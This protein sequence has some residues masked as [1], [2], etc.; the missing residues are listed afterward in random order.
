MNGPI[1]G[2]DSNCS[3]PTDLSCDY[4][5]N[6][7]ENYLSCGPKGY[8]L[9]YGKVYCQRFLDTN[10]TTYQ[11]ELWRDATLLCLQRELSLFVFFSPYEMKTC[12]SIM[13]YAYG[14]HAN[15][16]VSPNRSRSELSIC[17]LSPVD[18]KITTHNLKLV[19]VFRWYGLRQMA[20]VAKLCL[21][22]FNKNKTN[23]YLPG[24]SLE[25]QKIFWESMLI[26]E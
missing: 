5:N 3:R 24:N 19:D 15:C 25:E 9:G 4:Y 22:L 1:W 10:Y 2:F 13:K 8:A 16:Y 12:S 26:A 20:Q 18:I 14:T 23:P 11:A 7:V 21:E 6:C 17:Y